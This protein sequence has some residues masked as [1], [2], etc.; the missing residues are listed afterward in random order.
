MSF[1]IALQSGDRIAELVAGIAATP[2]DIISRAERM[3]RPD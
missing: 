1:E 3:S 2:P